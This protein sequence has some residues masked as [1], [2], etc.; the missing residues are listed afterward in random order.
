MTVYVMASPVGAVK[1]GLTQ[2]VKSRLSGVQT[3]SPHPIH[4][5]FQIETE[6]D[7]RIEKLAHKILAHARLNGE[8]FNASVDDAIRAIRQATETPKAP[9]RR[10]TTR[11]AAWRNF[12]KPVEADTLAEIERARDDLAEMNAEFRLIA[13]R[14]RLRMLKAR[15]KKGQ[16][17][18]LE[19]LP[20][21]PTNST[22]AT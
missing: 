15:T 8:W 18:R 17:N 19:N 10:K 3:G 21:K 6:D 13:E 14:A 5:A 9:R 1:I 4:V 12:L 7:R 2:D 16:E 22:P 20:K 11:D